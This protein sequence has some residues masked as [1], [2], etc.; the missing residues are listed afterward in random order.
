M[1]RASPA[2]HYKAEQATT[3]PLLLVLPPNLC[4][5]PGQWCSCRCVC[6]ALLGHSTSMS[7]SR[8]EVFYLCAAGKRYVHRV[9]SVHRSLAILIKQQSITE[10]YYLRVPLVGEAC[11]L[12]TITEIVQHIAC[13]YEN[14]IY[15]SSISCNFG[16]LWLK[17]S[18][19][20]LLWDYSLFSEKSH[21]YKN[22]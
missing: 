15:H 2:P 9:V 21:K 17:G 1:K 18:L 7:W 10:E 3:H 6:T 5:F 14:I 16:M 11:Q 22:R 4:S 20:T 8:A 19:A 12:Q 13:F